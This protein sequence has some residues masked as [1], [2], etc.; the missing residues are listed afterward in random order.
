MFGICYKGST[1]EKGRNR[2]IRGTEITLN[3]RLGL[4]ITNITVLH[5]NCLQI[6]S[7]YLL[8]IFPIHSGSF[9]IN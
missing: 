4:K 9:I 8:A 1:V 7:K 3:A 2:C 6:F 5:L